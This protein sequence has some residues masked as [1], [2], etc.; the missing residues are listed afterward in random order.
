MLRW[1]AEEF[2]SKLEDFLVT[3]HVQ[4][5]RLAAPLNDLN[6]SDLC[7]MVRRVHCDW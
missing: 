1:R 6:A 4:V 5:L 2:F 3:N 7:P